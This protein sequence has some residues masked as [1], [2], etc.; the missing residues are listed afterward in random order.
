MTGRWFLRQSVPF[1][2]TDCLLKL[3]RS[4]ANG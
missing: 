4:L 1:Y 2:Q 3:G